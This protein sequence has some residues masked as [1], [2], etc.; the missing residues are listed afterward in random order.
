VPVT[1]CIAALINFVYP[2][3]QIGR[4]AI[5]VADRMLTSGDIE[6]EPAQTKISFLHRRIIALVS[7]D[8]TVHSEAIT[9]ILRQLTV[10]P[11]DDVE[12]VADLYAA[13]IR[14]IRKHRATTRYLSPLNL[15]GDSFVTK[16]KDMLPQLVYDI[17]NQMQDYA[18]NVETLIVGCDGNLGAHLFHIDGY[19]LTTFHHDINFAA[20]GIGGDHARSQFMF[21]RYPRDVNL[22]KALPILYA[23]K[24][25]AEV[26]PGVGKESDWLLITKEGCQLIFPRMIRELEEAYNEYYATDQC[27][28]ARVEQRLADAMD[29]E[30]KKSQQV[31]AD[32]RPT[33]DI[34]LE[35]PSTQPGAKLGA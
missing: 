10:D 1:V 29:E 16:Q 12:R 26:A 30:I 21:A 15:N 27:R 32:Q 5:A 4:A 17:T 7:G 22:Y 33:E 31:D 14:A 20:I 8:I 19:G 6:Y 11:V 3:R 28:A 24:R 13:E 18:L 23:A 9:H 35:R 2:D 25:R 34:D